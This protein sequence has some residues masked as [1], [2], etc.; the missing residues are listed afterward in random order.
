MDLAV[1]VKTS[2]DY[3]VI[4]LFGLAWPDLLV[5]DVLR[6]RMEGPDLPRIAARVFQ[7]YRP[8]YFA[9]EQAGYQ[10]STVQ[11]MRRG[12]PAQ[13]PPRP[14]LPVK[15]VQP[16]GDKV[17]RALTLA[18]RMGGGHVYVPKNAPWLEGLFSEM[19]LFPKGTHDD[20]VDAIAYGALEAVAFGDNVL[21][22][23]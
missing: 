2:A 17:T 13:N 11:D 22:V 7:A 5:L 9:V 10:L 4:A 23:T 8:A 20:Q 15:G 16:Q 12:D 6:R 18:A 1:S 19:A 14:G 21:K 3:T